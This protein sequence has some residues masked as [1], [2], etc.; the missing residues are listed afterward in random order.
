[1]AN[2][3]RFG[4][5]NKEIAKDYQSVAILTTRP[6]AKIIEEDALKIPA[7][8]ASVELISNSISQLPIYLYVENDDLTID[9][10]KDTRTSILNEDANPYDTAQVIKKKVVQDFLLRGRAYLY[11]KGGK[12]YH[13]SPKNIKENTYTND[14]ITV[15]RK[16][17]IYQGMSTVNLQESE[18]IVIDSG[19]DGLLTDAGELFQT[20]LSQL[21][22]QQ[23]LLSNG[24]IPIGVLKAA[25][26][27]TETALT[28]LRSSFENL[29]GGS[30][31]SGKTIVLEEGLDYKPISLRPDELGLH[32]GNKQMTS[33]IARV[34]NIPES[35][36]N[37]QANKYNS[38]EANS[39][40]YLQ[41]TLAPI[42]TAIES[43]IDKNF[44]THSEKQLGYFFR[45]S[46][47][48]LLRVTE[49]ERI[50]TVSKAYNDGLISYNE[51]RYKI[52][53]KPQDKDVKKYSLG[54]VLVDTK[55]DELTIPNMGIVNNKQI[56]EVKATNANGTTK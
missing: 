16:E 51:M 30:K 33:E 35:L 3:F 54:D 37:S 40:S 5:S 13:L 6:S 21:D 20:A 49:K 48:E 14:G 50:E 24:A 39:I 4:G 31:K 8:K 23:S 34:F 26:R 29:Y 7:V 28:R 45:F 55:T 11:K 46:T 25:S 43:S 41:N 22:Y 18:V 2:P 38:L 27:L 1:M 53:M 17:F 32:E 19:T 42:I 52:D 10:V 36:I 15:S 9:K 47:D 44:L 56:L 12:L